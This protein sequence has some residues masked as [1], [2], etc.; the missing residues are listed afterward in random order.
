MKRWIKSIVCDKRRDTRCDIL[1]CEISQTEK[2]QEA[3]MGKLCGSPLF[4]SGSRL[5]YNWL[6]I[7]GW[8]TDPG[9]SSRSVTRTSTPQCLDP[10]RQDKW[11]TVARQ[12]SAREALNFGPDAHNIIIWSWSG[13][14]TYWAI[15]KSVL[16]THLLYIY[17]DRETQTD[18]QTETETERESERQRKKENMRIYKIRSDK[19]R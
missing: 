7:D 10:R 9:P 12:T 6:T 14:W 13:K 15:R 2:Q 3:G 1:S 19:I 11:P 4:P 5:V 16:L 18:R 17:I 8:P